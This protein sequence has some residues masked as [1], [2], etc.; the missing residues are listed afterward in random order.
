[1]NNFPKLK[2][3]FHSEK[4]LADATL[5]LVSARVVGTVKSESKS[6]K[7]IASLPNGVTDVS[8]LH[9]VRNRQG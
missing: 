6:H 5:S 8:R 4:R 2:D 3:M 9:P 7:V 1:M